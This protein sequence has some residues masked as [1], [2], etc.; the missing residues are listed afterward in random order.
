MRI[1][2][3]A[4]VDTVEK[5]LS[6]CPNADKYRPKLQHELQTGTRES[7]DAILN[8]MAQEMEITRQ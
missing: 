7:V 6:L 2:D 5:L 1:T 8:E 4:F 3:K